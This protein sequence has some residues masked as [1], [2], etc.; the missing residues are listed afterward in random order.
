MSE[1]K[2][3]LIDLER[4]VPSGIIHYWKQNRY[5]YVTDRKEAG[6]FSYEFARS[7]VNEDR[8]FYTA[9]YAADEE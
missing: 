7:T 4:T 2:Y 1:K 5:G 3:Y 8:D 9:M 6:R